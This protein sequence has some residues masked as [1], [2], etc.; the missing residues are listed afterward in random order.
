MSEQVFIGDVHPFANRPTD[1][2]V[3]CYPHRY[4]IDMR[5]THMGYEQR[6]VWLWDDGKV[7]YE[8]WIPSPFKP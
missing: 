1:E 3:Y 4:R 2:S 6:H 7:Q 5:K 8:D